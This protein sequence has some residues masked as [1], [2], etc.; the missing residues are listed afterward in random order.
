MFGVMATTGD[1]REERKVGMFDLRARLG[2]W[3]DRVQRGETLVVTRRG[4]P[5]AR[6]VPL[7]PPP[8]RRDPVRVR[9]A[10][11]DLRKLREKIRIPPG[12][13][14]LDWAKEGRR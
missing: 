14:P 5:V 11:E 6:I 2:R 3:L 12:E 8:P 9:R 10:I 7:P 13:N 4:E 1:R